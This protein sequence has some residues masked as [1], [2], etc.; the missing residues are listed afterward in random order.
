MTGD[1]ALAALGARGDPARAAAMADHHKAPRRYLGTPATEIEALVRLWREGAT[2]EDRLTLAASLWDSDVHEARIAAAKLL[3]QARIRPD[4]EATWRL[5]ASWVPC[6]DAWAIA[7]QASK[8]GERRLVADPRRLDEVE[9]WVVSPH[10][11]T[12]RATL[13]MTLPWTRDRFAKPADLEVRERV[14]GWCESLASDP[15]ADVQRAIAGWLRDLSKRDPDRVRAWLEAHGPRLRPFA[16]KEAA[17]LL[18]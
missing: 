10:P 2:I 3:T 9:G 8:A 15:D 6:F 11:W 18:S 1:E 13:V 16:R 5:I 14:L 17:Q 4:D 12:R 7:D